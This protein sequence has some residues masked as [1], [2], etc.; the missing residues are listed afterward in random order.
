MTVYE[1]RCYKHRVH[2]SRRGTWSNSWSEVL[3]WR[4]VS[5]DTTVSDCMLF[6]QNPIISFSCDQTLARSSL[7]PSLISTAHIQTLFL[8][9]AVQSGW[10][11]EDPVMSQSLQ[12]LIQNTCYLHQWWWHH[13]LVKCRVFQTPIEIFGYGYFTAAW[14]SVNLDCG[15]TPEPSVVNVHFPFI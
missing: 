2:L 13:H 7:K 4:R 14:W 10:M 5:V 8:S 3:W 15:V 9:G 1:H 12:L 6:F 11:V